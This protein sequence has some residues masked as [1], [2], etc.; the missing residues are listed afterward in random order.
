MLENAANLTYDRLCKEIDSV[1][2]KDRNWANFAMAMFVGKRVVM[3]TSR[4]CRSVSQYFSNYI[5]QEFS[6]VIQQAGGM[7]RSNQIMCFFFSFKERWGLVFTVFTA[8]V[9]QFFS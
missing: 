1:V 5:G 6:P 3:E 2:G 4:A 7:V 8:I 9:M